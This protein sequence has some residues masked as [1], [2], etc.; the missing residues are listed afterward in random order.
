MKKQTASGQIE[1]EPTIP[2]FPSSLT[3][4]RGGRGGALL[5][6]SVLQ[7]PIVKWKSLACLLPSRTDSSSSCS[8]T[9]T[10][11][12]VPNKKLHD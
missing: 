7:P 6:A 10:T 11:P 4:E 9:N 2:K 8:N 5:S 12:V 3:V 1:L